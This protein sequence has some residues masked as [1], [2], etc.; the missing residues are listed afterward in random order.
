TDGEWKESVV[1][2]VLR[3]HLGGSNVVGRGFVVGQAGASRQVDVLIFDASKPVLFRDDDLAF[4]TPDAV[5]GMIEVKSR[6]TPA[7]L[8]KAAR[9]LARD[10]ALL[11]RPGNSKAFAGIFAFELDGGTP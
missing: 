7:T 3:R 5:I 1:R 11:R 8:G 9:K 2:Q 10:M 4:V 6:V